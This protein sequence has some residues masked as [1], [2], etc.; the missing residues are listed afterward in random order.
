MAEKNCVICDTAFE[1]KTS[2]QILCGSHKCHLARRRVTEGRP[3]KERECR[4][5]GKAFS[6]GYAGKS[7]VQYYCS[8]ECTGKGKKE[9]MK[10]YRMK[11]RANPQPKECIVC[12]TTF[13]HGRKGT[14]ICSVEC[15]KVHRKEYMKQYMT[16]RNLYA[17]R[18]ENCVVCGKSFRQLGQSLTCS[19]ECSKS[20]EEARLK[21]YVKENRAKITK[22]QREWRE[23]K[24]PPKVDIQCREC[25]E[26]YTPTTRSNREAFCS[27]SCKVKW[28]DKDPK[29]NISKR[30]RGNMLQCLKK[31]G[32]TKGGKTFEILGYTPT[33]LMNH[34][35]SQFVE[36]MSW[37]NR[38]EWHIDH[39][40]PISSFDFDSTDHPDFKEC[41][42]LSNLQPLWASDNIKKGAKWNGKDYRNGKGGKVYAED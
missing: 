31:R 10:Q 5:C 15:K 39:I 29:T 3:I 6:Q 19:K 21:R 2:R 37:D 27:Y 30:V 40:R 24:R 9:Y 34:L 16:K 22:R 32:I 23:S 41:W 12:G 1:Q 42:A 8:K 17:N 11:N 38:G 26:Y 20:L 28:W 7:G 35:E 36:G 25:K 4:H 33:D 18:I 14:Q 13:T